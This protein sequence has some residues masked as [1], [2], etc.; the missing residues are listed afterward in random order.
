MDKIT[1][2]GTGAAMVTKC[3]NTCFTLSNVDSKEY[4]LIDT[5]GGNTIL[6]NLEKENISIKEIHNVFISHSHNDHITGIVWIIRAVAQKIIN[7][8]YEGSLHIYCHESVMKIIRT[9]SSLLLQDKFTKYIDDRIKF[10][11]I[12]NKSLKNILGYELEFFDIK[13]TKLLQYGFTAK[14]TD[15]K[16]FTF[17][18]DEPFNSDLFDFAVGSDYIMHEAYCLYSDR[19]IFKPYGKHHSTVKDASVNAAKLNAKNLI[20][21]HTEDKNLAK[22]KQ[23]YTREGKEFFEGNIIVPEDLETIN[24]I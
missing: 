9:V 12:D 18:G 14:L 6:S 5:G 19:E 17:L 7:G 23:L 21:M 3:Y 1:M 13:S 2:L 15:G 11:V 20:L 4:F 22:R 10:V 24:L 16:K 8:E